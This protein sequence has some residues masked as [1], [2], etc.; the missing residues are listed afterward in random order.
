MNE[1]ESADSRANV[2]KAVAALQEGRPVILP[3]DTVYGLAVAPRYTDSPDQLFA[4]KERPQSKP[5]AWLVAGVEDLDNYGTNVPAYARY[6]ARRYWPGPLTI[7]VAANPAAVPAAFQSEAGTIGL[8]MP[9]DHL[10]REIIE[11]V[12]SPLATTSANLSGKEPPRRFADI[13]PVLASRVPVA[14]DDEQ[15]KS[16]LP[17][18]VVDCS[19]AKPRMLREGAVTAAQVDEAVA[20]CTAEDAVSCTSFTLPS[21]D[22]FSRLYARCWLPADDNPV[23]G[24]VLVVHGMAEHSGRYDG[25]AR[26]LASRGLAVYAH[27]HIGHGRSV[28]SRAQWGCLPG[29]AGA[30]VLVDDVHELRKAATAHHQTGTPVILFGHSMGSFIARSYLARYGNRLAAAI[31]SGTA[32]QPRPVVGVGHAIADTLAR[33]K[34][35]DYRSWFLDNLGVGGYSKDIPDA[36]TP[37]DWLS[38]DEAV[39]DAYAADPACGFMFSAG[40]YQALM[41][42][43]ADI[44][45]P[46]CAAG[47]PDG[48]PVLFA[49][50]ADDPV[51]DHG[52]GVQAAANEMQKRSNAQVQ[53]KIYPGMRHEILNEKNHRQVWQDLAQ[54]IEEKGLRA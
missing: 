35:S 22:G 53:V 41:T 21:T 50:G 30:R 3:T 51:G 19:G 31:I 24:I 52:K 37:Y 25:F 17:S 28:E 38:T 5:V 10:T 36:R 45:T 2:D 32:Q 26:F 39:V 14:I 29:D 4:I 27:D 43:L 44:A 6:L 9:D 7:I 16:G 42:L 46:A 40:G 33:S 49:A 18:T 48:L 54:W 11:R 34:G 8:R 12:H 13:D 15:R 47:V 1:N 23:R 20:A